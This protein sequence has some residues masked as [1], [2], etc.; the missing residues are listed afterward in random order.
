[1]VSE[2][3]I[4]E[5]RRIEEAQKPYWRPLRYV[6]GM[7]AVCMQPFDEDDYDHSRYMTSRKFGTEESCLDF[8]R[9][10]LG[11]SS[12]SKSLLKGKIKSHI[13]HYGGEMSPNDRL[14]LY[15]AISQEINHAGGE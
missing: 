15:H 7:V 8:I 13:E 2:E 1:M 14:M 10:V 3:L 4:D 6:D 9:E 5:V 11:K 12:C